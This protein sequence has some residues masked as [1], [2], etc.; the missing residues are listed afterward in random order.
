MEYEIDKTSIKA[1]LGKDCRYVIPRFQRAFSWHK[2]ECDTL[3]DDFLSELRCDSGA[4]HSN[5]YFLGTMIFL[6]S[7]DDARVEVIDGQQRLTSITLL[8]AALRDAFFGMEAIDGVD[9]HTLAK[10]IQAKYIISE[11]IEGN[12]GPIVRTETSFPFFN[13][14]IQRNESI[15]DIEPANDE[16]ELLFEMFTRFN[17]DLSQK[18]LWRKL[19]WLISDN[20][21]SQ[22]YFEVLKALR[23]QILNSS[24]VAIYVRDR[25]QGNRIFENINSKGLPLSTIDLIKNAVFAALAKDDEDD[26]VNRVW[27]EMRD[28]F[29]Q[30]Q[31]T[32]F[33]DFIIDYWKATY[34]DDSPTVRN[35]YQ[36]YLHRVGSSTEKN[37]Q[38][39]ADLKLKSKIYKDIVAP[40]SNKYRQQHQKYRMQ[41]LQYLS[42]AGY[43]KMRPALLSFFSWELQPGHKISKPHK[44]EFL[45]FLSNFGFAAFGSGYKLRSNQTS[46]PF[47]E[48]SKQINSASDTNE[49]VRICET[50]YAELANLLERERFV[51]SFIELSF[52]KKN[53]KSSNGAKYAIRQLANKAD[54]RD[55]SDDMS[56]IEH[57]IDEGSGVEGSANIGNLLLLETPINETLGVLTSDQDPSAHFESKKIQYARSRYK[58]TQDFVSRYNEVGGFNEDAIRAR[59]LDLANEFWDSFIAPYQK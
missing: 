7:S 34:P 48:F 56:S 41:Y 22:T 27:N 10:A 50:L 45:R 19:D 32:N 58:M 46:T 31:Y 4:I 47:K 9:P 44:L 53:S 54:N 30:N 12:F 29:F 15:T 2:K 39:L 24:I 13:R 1:L 17:Q 36:R 57:V 49:L 37:K 35:L 59:A 25:Q 21:N 18:T 52:S 3:L 33:D 20:G 42:D 43:T 55:Y 38:L 5:G 14:R 11:D 51:Q 8:L 16:E 40:D 28:A 26:E 23:D 6:G